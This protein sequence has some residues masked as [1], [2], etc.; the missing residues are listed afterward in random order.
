[1]PLEKLRERS[2]YYLAFGLPKDSELKGVLN[3]HLLKLI[4]SG[5]TERLEQKW[6]RYD[7]P[8]DVSGRIFNH[9]V[10]I[11]GLGNLFFPM[12]VM[13]AGIVSGLTLVTSEL[14]AKRVN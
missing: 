3:Y 11:L 2:K 1:M 8:G 13:L 4:Q 12:F 5:V 6:V 10:L 14:V 7:N 9:D